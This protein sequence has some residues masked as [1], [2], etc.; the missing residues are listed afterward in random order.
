MFTMY[1]YILIIAKIKIMKVKFATKNR[2]RGF[3]I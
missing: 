1:D 3:I 2:K